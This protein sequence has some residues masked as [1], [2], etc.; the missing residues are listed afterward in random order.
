VEPQ[1]EQKPSWEICRLIAKELGIEEKYTEGRTQDEWVRWC[2][3]QTRKK[4]PQLPE[5]EQ[6]WRDGMAK[7]WGWNKNPV[8]LAG[9]R[10]DPVKNKLKTPSGKIE[11]Y[12]ERLAKIAATWELKDDELISALPKF[13]PAFEMAAFDPLAKKYPLQCVGYHFHGRTHSSYHNVPWLRELHPDH[14]LVNPVDAEPRGIK[15]GDKVKVFNG[16]GALVVTAKVTPRIIPGATAIPQGAW[17]SLNAQ[18]VDEGACINTLTSL[19]PSP[20]SKANPQHTN[21]VE[22]SKVA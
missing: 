18:G 12:S 9:F 22:I 16:R 17:R 20:L 7:V 10:R 3:E 1:W 21:L 14:V 8:A 2:Y 4:V 13:T 6:F 5:F 15:S 11:I 19:R